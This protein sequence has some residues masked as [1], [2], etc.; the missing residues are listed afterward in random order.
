MKLSFY[1]FLILIVYTNNLF[2]Q[3]KGNSYQFPERFSKNYFFDPYLSYQKIK[4]VQVKGFT[5]DQ[6]EYYKIMKTFNVQ[7]GFDNNEYYLGWYDLEKYL[8]KLIDTILPDEIKNKQPY[9]VFIQRDIDYNASALGNGFVFANIGLIANCKTEAELAYILAHEIG[10]SIFN[11]GYMINSDFVSAY[12][13]NDYDSME[14][15]F[16][17]MFEKSQYAELQSDSFAYKC[18]ESVKYNLNA[19]SSSLDLIGY[20][21]FTSEFYVNKNR[22]SSFKSYMNTFSTHPSFIKRKALLNKEIRISNYEGKNYIIDSVYF[23]K[24]K[25]IAH[26][27]CKKISMESGDF[28]N[29][30][31][32][33]F[34]DYLG[35]DNGLKNIYFLFES[36]RRYMYANP[37]SINKGFL[38]EDLQFTEFEN[39]NY[40]VLK[41]P[42]IL[43]SEP[44]Q[45]NKLSKHPLITN[46][47]KP[48]NTYEQAYLY[49]VNLA[50]EKGFNESLFSQALFY[51]FKKDN[52]NF[53]MKL[54]SYLEKGGG[55]FTDLA[56]NLK[57]YG[58]PFIK[59]GKT[60]VLI[61]N[62]TNFSNNDNYYHSLQ[63][64]GFNQSIYNIFKNDSN[65]VQLTLMNELIGVFPKK[66]YD[67]Q[68]LKWNISQIYNEDDEEKFF[69]K[70]YTSKEDMDEREKRNKFNKNIIIYVPEWY[71]WFTENNYNG[72][73]YQRIK[74]EYPSVK[75]N[76]E[77]HNFY[78]IGYFNFFD[79][80]P[81]F[82]KC[83]RNGN[84]RKQKTEDMAKD[85]R[86]FLLYKE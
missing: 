37:E 40:S 22:R 84:I 15:N 80:R 76:D 32:L 10:H 24:V 69:K 74:Y 3:L 19:I 53:S 21:E 17:K 83:I 4:D 13:N 78:S 16:Y 9:D 34:I 12:N 71:K 38:A 68:K 73:L 49:F 29:A 63:R 18:I 82:A 11:H 58:F 54:N 70:R 66:L 1:Y 64:I 23:N 27:E 47:I 62:S 7:M 44:E 2:S 26:D 48:F 59:N 35:G 50:E 51:Y 46:E 41:K 25:K 60:N 42:E 6:M 52:T 86:E 39:T 77:F 30:M 45:F 33:S 85:A 72:I 14:K 8:F 43:F 55:L 79:N 81:F 61:D 65:K 57:Q 56:N 20:A 75:A 67:Y 36:I 5:A 31:K 28:E